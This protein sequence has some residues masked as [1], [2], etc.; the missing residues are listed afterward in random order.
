MTNNPEFE[1]GPFYLVVGTTISQLGKNAIIWATD[2]NTACG[3]YGR[4]IGIR[5]YAYATL[6]GS[7]EDVKKQYKMSPNQLTDL[8]REGYLRL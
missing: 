4:K 3:V 5:T 6:L 8:H 1:E 2:E 7:L